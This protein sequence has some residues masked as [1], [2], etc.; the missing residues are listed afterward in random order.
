MI[1][2]SIGRGRHKHMIA[3]H[4]F[5]VEQGIELCELRLDYITGPVKLKRL[6]DNRAGPVIVTCRRERDGGRW[7]GDETERQMMLRTAVVEGADYV[8]IEEDIAE[9]IPRYG[10]TKRVISYHN[11]RETPADLGAIHARMKQYDPDIVK[12]ATMANSPHDN[13]RMLKLVEE[14]DVSTLGLCMGEMGMPSR[15]LGGRAGVPFTFATSSNERTMAPGQI[16]FKQMLEVYRYEKISDA[17]KLFGVVADPVGHSLSPQL[18]NAAFIDR[19]LDACYLPFRV[20][21]EH[22]QSFLEEDCPALGI[23]GLSVTIPHKENAVPLLK[24]SDAIVQG[25]GATNT[26]VFDEQGPS[27]YNTDSQGAMESLESVLGTGADL[28]SKVVLVLG[29]GGVARAIAWTLKQ[30]GADV[31]ISGRTPEKAEALAERL[32]CRNIPW[33]ERGSVGP[34]IL[35]NGT[36]LGMHPNVNESPFPKEWLKASM[37]VFDTVYNP[38][39]TLLIKEARE[40]QAKVVT[41]VEMFVRQA[42]LQ[43]KWFTG[44][45]ISRDLMRT[46]LK[47]ITA[48]VRPS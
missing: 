48:A 7:S 19:G 43:F 29:S 3:E 40:K 46:E 44:E 36:P 23:Q 11:F 31:V 24:R 30:R 37:V 2:V 13:V 41:G 1:C 25:V 27:G 12:L 33:N 6:L 15:L 5:L 4:K 34:Q 17:T 20:P 26:I 28:T 16:G 45:E 38:E 42:A 9:N 22:L 14:S 39:Q 32:K 47:R 8:D 21:R 18:H 35:V 10:K